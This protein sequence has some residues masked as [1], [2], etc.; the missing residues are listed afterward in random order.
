MPRLGVGMPIIAGL[1]QEAVTTIDDFFFES[2]ASG[3]VTPINTATRTNLL[4]NSHDFSQ[5][6]WTK[7]DAAVSA[8][9]VKNPFGES[10]TAANGP[11]KLVTSSASNQ[12][13]IKET[14]TSGIVSGTS[15]TFSV[16]AQ[17]AE[18]DYVSLVALN[19]TTIHYFNLANGTTASAH[20]IQPVIEDAGNGWYRCSVTVVADNS[21]SKF[22]GIYLA[23][24]SG[25]ISLGSVADGNGVYIYG[26][27]VEQNSPVSALITSSGEPGTATTALSD[28]SEVWDFDSTDIMLE[29]DPEDEGFWEEGSNLVL[30]GDYEDLGSELVTNGDFSNGTASFNEQLGVNFSV[31]NGVATIQSTGNN[32]LIHQ[33]ISPP[34]VTTILQIEIDVVSFTGSSFKVQFGGNTINSTT[35]GKHFLFTSSSRSNNKMDISPAANETLVIRSI[36][37]KQVDPNDRWV[38]DST[39][40]IEDGKLKA[41]NGS[42]YGAYQANI[43][44][45]GTTYEI[46]YTISD[47]SSGT[48]GI[49]AHTS[50]GITVTANGTYTDIITSNGPHLYILGFGTFNGSVD[51]VTVREYAVQPKDI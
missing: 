41:V 49:R 32:S 27:Q 39:Y 30:N 16:F 11:Y 21:T 20:G 13:Y 51:N 18:Y 12:V 42:T 3:E 43:L 29:A 6:S 31:T 14:I 7:A 35:T 40:S 45:S 9:T 19:P 47:Y 37:A 8:S 50:S 26:A 22:F 2:N 10:A 23:G 24:D 4:T 33:T 34:A 36:S 48:F 5:S 25:S 46:K 28:T 1:S 44:T 38:L 15:Y 17:K